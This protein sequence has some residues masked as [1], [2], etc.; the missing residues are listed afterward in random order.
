MNISLVIPVYN[1][2]ANIQKGV[3]DKIGNYTAEKNEYTEVLIVD[4]GS[5]DK[6]VVAIKEQYLPIF[7]KFRLIE[8]THRGKA[9]AILSGIEKAKGDYILFSDADLATPIEESEKMIEAA[10]KGYKIVIGSRDSNRSGAPYLRRLMAVGFIFIRDI[11]LNMYGIRDTQCGFKLF[12]KETALKIIKKLQVFKIKKAASGPSVS[13]GFDLEFLYI[14]AQL[15]LK[16]KEIPVSWR[17]VETHN[18]NFVK[19][20]VETLQDIFKIK[21]FTLISKYK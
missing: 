6:S 20:T 19:D 7:N 1:E 4:D 15:K 12:E 14:A 11:F 13:A 18:V 3:F 5:T 9:Y 21:Y 16:I 8:N 10:K 17:H 2:E